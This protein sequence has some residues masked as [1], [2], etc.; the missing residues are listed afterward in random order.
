MDSG[1]RKPREVLR[2]LGTVRWNRTRG[3]FVV[4]TELGATLQM[5]PNSEEALAAGVHVDEIAVPEGRRRR[6]TATKAIAALCRLADEYALVLKGGP[7]GWSDDP[8]REQFVAWLNRFGVEPDP[9]PPT[10]VHDRTAFYVRRLPR[11]FRKPVR[12]S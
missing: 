3:A 8:W 7:V 9:S 2:C 12:S 6:G 10:V 1:K 4:E 11:P 5:C